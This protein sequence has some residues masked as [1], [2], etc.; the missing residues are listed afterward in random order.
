MS[1]DALA[2]VPP[3]AYIKDTATAKGM[4][5]FAVRA[6]NE[7]DLVERCPVLLIPCRWDE[8]PKNFQVRVF[9][10]GYF[11]GTPNIHAFALGWG[12]LYNHNDPANLRYHV[13]AESQLLIFTTVRSIAA[14]EELTINYQAKGGG[15]AGKDFD[16]FEANTITPVVA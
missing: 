8:L 7:G 12:S 2:L 16:W 4:G 13:N 5:V 6:F 1:D 9:D 3:A 15:P 11:V 10:W 14:N